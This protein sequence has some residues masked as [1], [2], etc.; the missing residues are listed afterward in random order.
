MKTHDERITA[1]VARLDKLSGQRALKID[2]DTKARQ[3]AIAATIDD[4]VADLPEGERAKFF[5]GIEAKASGRNRKLIEGHPSRPATMPK[6][7]PEA[8]N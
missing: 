2:R 7:A 1:L 6:A 5:A 3:A 4:W 8:L